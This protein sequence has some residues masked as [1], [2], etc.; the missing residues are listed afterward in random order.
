[1]EKMSSKKTKVDI[2][3][4]GV[5]PRRTL[6]L[7]AMNAGD[8]PR[9]YV[10]NS[11]YQRGAVD[12]AKPIIEEEIARKLDIKHRSS[13]SPNGFWVADFGC[14]TGHNSFPAMQIITRAIYRK[15]ASSG[16]IT[17]QIPEVFVLFNDV[18]TND[19][20]TLFTSL[21]PRRRY[22]AIRLPGDFHSRLLP[23]SSLHFAYSSWALQWLTQVPKEVAERDSPAWNNRAILYTRDRKEVCDAYLNQYAKDIEAFM[24]ARAVE[25]V[26][27]GLMAILVPA[28]PAFWNPE[29]E[30]TIPSDLNLL[31][32]CLVDM[33]KTGKFSEA[34][35]D[36]FNLPFY[37]TTP[38]QLKAILERS[39]SFTLERLE[40]LNNP[41]KYTLPSVNARAAFYRAVLEGLLTDHFGSDIIDELFTLY[42]EKLA[43]LPVFLNPDKDKSTVILAVLKRRSE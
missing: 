24:E 22:T 33:A 23:E 16:L 7:Y 29:T 31:G 20:N 9:S 3:G 8:G 15:H 2:M 42:M 19:F 30:Y 17:S 38:E 10:Q 35:V 6:D 39:H 11:S 21:P 28:V 5:L 14:S 25:M 27:G 18:I 34:K 37:F 13:T 4:N 41:G 1:M 40:I 36:S 26:S 32:S 12:I 43:A